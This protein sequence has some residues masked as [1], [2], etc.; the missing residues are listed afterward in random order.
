MTGNFFRYVSTALST[1]DG[2]RAAMGFSGPS[3]TFLEFPLLGVIRL[4]GS[5]VSEINFRFREPDPEAF[6]RVLGFEARG[7]VRAH[8]SFLLLWHLWHGGLP[9]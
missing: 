7:S 6:C 8:P 9:L 4:T 2:E 3:E 5:D 1:V